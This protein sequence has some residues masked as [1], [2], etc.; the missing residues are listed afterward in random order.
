M[1]GIIRG[2][3]VDVRPGKYVVAVSGGVDSVALLHL[4]VNQPHTEKDQKR[5][6]VV[7]HFDHG[8]RDD[9]AYDRQLVQSLAKQYK[10]PFVYEQGNLGIGASENTA[11]IARY[12]FL[13][14]VKQASNAD[15]IVTAHHEDDLLETAILNLLRGT[16]RKGM[17][18]L[19][20]HPHLRRPLLHVSKADIQAYA[21]EQGLV[22]H[23]DSTNADTNLKRNY[24]RKV[25]VP[26][27]GV[28]GRKTLLDIVRHLKVV[29]ASLDENIALYLHTQ[30]SRQSLNRHAFIQLPHAVA[31][32]VMASWLRSHGITE[33]DSK[34][35]ESLVVK[36]KTLQ[37]G[38][39]VDV[40][41]KH[42]MHMGQDSVVLVHKAVISK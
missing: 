23:E 22:W 26:G 40:D 2:M 30:P 37:P 17:S 42:R 29:N 9:S 11:R 12:N 41:A 34:L 20:D 14:K 16:G 15:A 31:L 6:F 32:E 38:K 21:K 3:K 36:V 27:L 1:G 19:G 33:F 13:E 10:L 4:L 35:L 7:A 25:L 8:I 18:S 5:S 39:S 28:N 24:V